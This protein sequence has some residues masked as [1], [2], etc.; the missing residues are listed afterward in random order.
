MPLHHLLNQAFLPQRYTVLKFWIFFLLS[1]WKECL[2]TILDGLWVNLG[3]YG[4]ITNLCL[5]FRASADVTLHPMRGLVEMAR[6]DYLTCIIHSKLAL[7]LFLPVLHFITLF[8]TFSLIATLLFLEFLIELHYFEQTPV[9]P[10][11][12]SF[13]G[14]KR[15]LWVS[16]HSQKGISKSSSSFLTHFIHLVFSKCSCWVVWECSGSTRGGADQFSLFL[17]IKEGKSTIV[18]FYFAAVPGNWWSQMSPL[19]LCLVLYNVRKVR[20]TYN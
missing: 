8:F 17:L 18:Q 13:W 4:K 7:S 5:D 9:K 6:R 12:F 11:S 14:C 16:L 2:F 15:M 10:L 3:P 20:Q 1:A 19:P